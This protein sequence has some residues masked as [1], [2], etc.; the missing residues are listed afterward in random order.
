MF[1]NY[2]ADTIGMIINDL[3]EEIFSEII[4]EIAEEMKN[5][6]FQDLTFHPDIV[7]LDCDENE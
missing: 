7:Q 3:F 1:V 2:Y 6:Q 5:L 4:K